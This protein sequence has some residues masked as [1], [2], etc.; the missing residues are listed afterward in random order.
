MLPNTLSE[1][2]IASTDAGPIEYRTIG[3]GTPVLVLHGSPGGIDQ[4]ALMAR[5]LPQDGIEA[6]TVSRPGY[7]G[8]P[9]G[10][11]PSFDD[12]AALLIALL[13]QLG[14]ERAGILAW[15]GA[16]PVAYRLAALYPDRISA[17]V[18]VAAVSQAFTVPPMDL[19]SRFLMGTRLGGRVMRMLVEHQSEQV[20]D[21][22]LKSE[23]T[24]TAEQ[25]HA[26]L[27][28]VMAD[29]DK[30]QFVLDLAST[31]DLKAARKPGYARDCR[32]FA[33]IESLELERIT[34]PSLIVGGTADAE[35]PIAHVEHAAAMIPDARLRAMET[36]TH[37]SFFTH[38]DAAA[39]QAEAVALLMGER[40]QPRV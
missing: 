23:G 12:E 19:S 4:A 15:S 14:H 34:Q 3:S 8:T 20:V 28:E 35:L 31:V 10:D 40:A 18:T 16:G 38:P 30:R 17:L 32:L 39:V 33:Q 7:L 9:L 36:G 37:L 13:D 29:G 21:A 11:F 1:S 5:V 27:E 6:V 25:R 2:T 24:L 22:T 26:R